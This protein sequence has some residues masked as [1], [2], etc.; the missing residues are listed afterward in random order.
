MRFINLFLIVALTMSF[1][2]SCTIVDTG[3]RKEAIE[4]AARGAV[5]QIVYSSLEKDPSLEEF[6]CTL[7]EVIDGVDATITLSPEKVSKV[8]SNGVTHYTNKDFSFIIDGIVTA[9]FIK[10]DIR[11]KDDVDPSEISRYLTEL[12]LSVIEGLDYYNSK[13]SEGGE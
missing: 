5:S 10:Y 13:K 1:S 6:Y 7:I 9:F 4:V 11:W 3:N 8:I 2:V 12:K